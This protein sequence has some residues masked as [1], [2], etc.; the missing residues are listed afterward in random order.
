MIKH[1]KSKRGISF[2]IITPPQTLLLSLSSESEIITDEPVMVRKKCARNQMHGCL[3]IASNVG[4]LRSTRIHLCQ[5]ASLRS[6]TDCE[7]QTVVHRVSLRSITT[8]LVVF[9]WHYH[10][11]TFPWIDGISQ[12]SVTRNRTATAP[13]W[14]ERAI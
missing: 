12:R 1:N 3:W 7:T 4:Q 9:G 13:R 8:D 6:L 14:Q 11:Y 10:L 2:Q 5:R